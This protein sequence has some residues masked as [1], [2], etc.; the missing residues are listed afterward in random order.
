MPRINPV[1]IETANQ[2]TQEI[3]ATVKKKMGRVPNLISTM[4]QAPAVA[5]AYLGFSQAL[6]TGNLPAR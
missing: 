4:A 2:K 6:A 3:L 5:N 1:K